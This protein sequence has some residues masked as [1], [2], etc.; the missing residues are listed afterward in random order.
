MNC[1]ATPAPSIAHIP[2]F[3][4]N[5][6][7]MGVFAFP[8]LKCIAINRAATELTGYEKEDFIG[9]TAVEID[10]YS[11]TIDRGFLQKELLRGSPIRQT[12]ILLRTR[13]GQNIL[14]AVSVSLIRENDNTYLY[15]VLIEL[16]RFAKPASFG[17]RNWTRLHSLQQLGHVADWEIDIRTRKLWLSE[18]ALR[19]AGLSAGTTSFD[20]S[21]I[22]NWLPTLTVE[23]IDDALQ[24]RIL[25]KGIC[26]FEFKLL[27]KSDNEEVYLESKSVLLEVDG[28]PERISGVLRDI[29]DLRVESQ[30]IEQNAA[31]LR[32]VV[33]NITD[34][35]VVLDQD[36]KI[37]YQ[38]PNSAKYLGWGPDERLG[39]KPWEYIHKDDRKRVEDAFSKITATG[40]GSGSVLFRVIT[41]SG[42]ERSIE[43][44]A[45]NLLNDEHIRGILVHYHDIT[46]KRSAQIERD[47]TMHLLRYIVEHNHHSIAVHDK[48]M[49]YLYVSQRY[50][51]GLGLHDC[52]IIGRNHY[53]VFPNLPQNLVD[54]HQK[55]L[56]GEIVK[57]D[58]YLFDCGEK[59]G[60]SRWECRPWYEEDGSIGGLIVYAEE[61]DEEIQ[62]QETLLKE[63]EQFRTTLLSVGDGVIATD[64]DGKIRVMNRVAEQLTEKSQ[65]EAIGRPVEE[66]VRIVDEETG[67][68]YPNPVLLSLRAK[69]SV[70]PAHPLELLSPSGKRLPIECTASPIRN[71]ETQISTGAVLVFRDFSEKRAKQKQVEF[72]SF[73]DQLT[74]LYNRRFFEE[75]TRKCRSKADL[76]TS[77]I[78]FD[79]NGLKLINDAFGH[80]AGD[81]LLK[82]VA[83]VLEQN[84]P[85]NSCIARIGGDEFVILLPRCGIESAREIVRSIKE[86]VNQE[87]VEGIQISVSVGIGVRRD[88]TMSVESVQKE[89]EDLMYRDKI[90]DRNNQRYE[91]I[92]MIMRTL[93]EKSPREREHSRR[94]GEI[95]EKI[96]EEIGLT[97]N[98]LRALVTAGE[99]HDI[100]KIAI[101]NDILNK[102]GGLSSQEMTEI[103]R[104][105]EVGYNILCSANAYAPL[106]D[107]VW[108]HHERW[109]GN[110]Y[111]NS[112][113]GERIPLF[114][115]II[116]IADSYDAMIEDRPYRKA[117]SVEQTL[118][119]ITRCSGTQFDPE[120]ARIF[121]RQ[122]APELNSGVVVI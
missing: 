48:N 8:S 118:A 117:L 29:T 13:A 62:M 37:T 61:I 98:E 59:T 40:I 32:A 63:K 20:L 47:H 87:R 7:P 65:S 72:L 56:N 18:E 30:K 67:D 83:H 121:V 6:S 66:I 4:D 49:N 36:G 88:N 39:Y 104:H 57:A 11:D 92:Q 75:R 90:F 86:R 91:A 26:D 79:V 111:P 97:Q 93:H 81:R 25:D 43:L 108:A 51:D 99:L 85:G 122:V 15:C 10:I 42:L 31:L 114:A 50:L 101:S 9:K 74:G 28:V 3:D 38:S 46:E 119:E 73:H 109:D 100:G 54:A 78:M 68:A 105:P 82:A 110:G 44:F 35:I 69:L 21:S 24:R 34:V 14:S 106:A 80:A 71:E 55:A 27:R 12:P 96:G 22:V 64:S 70:H 52:D 45:I 58:R 84:C 53:D 94:V 2:F 102:T 41:K 1:D 17:E 103:R 116:A 23:G 107:I 120:L 5:V 95:S 76:P 33:S 113:S 77:V 60:W 115:R 16:P 19:L 112:L 89:A